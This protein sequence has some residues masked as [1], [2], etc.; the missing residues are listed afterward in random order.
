MSWSTTRN[1]STAPTIPAPPST[2]SRR[3]R[4]SFSELAQRTW[5]KCVAL[6]RLG[7]G[8]ADPSQ[9]ILRPRA[10]RHRDD[11]AEDLGRQSRKICKSGTG[12]EADQPPPDA[13]QHGTAN[14]RSVDC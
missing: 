4:R 9:H 2:G 8:S 7:L 11:E 3:A 10:D 1:S 13:E 5:T 12:A 14:Q 6:R